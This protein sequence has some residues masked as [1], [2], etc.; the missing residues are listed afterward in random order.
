MTLCRQEGVEQVVSDGYYLGLNVGKTASIRLK[1]MCAKETGT[2]KLIIN[3]D[4]AGWDTEEG[5][6]CWIHS[7]V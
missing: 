1:K 4:D 2:K 6:R 5:K 7:G 3:I